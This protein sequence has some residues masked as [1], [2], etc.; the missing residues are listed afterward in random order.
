M[1]SI[2]LPPNVEPSSQAGVDSGARAS[3]TRTLVNLWPHIWPGDRADLKR[4]VVWS[5]VL[6]SIGLV[7][8][9]QI[10]KGKSILITVIFWLLGVVFT[11]GFAALGQMMS[12]AFVGAG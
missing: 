10:S 4:R 1:A 8:T 9:Y 12:S 3:L 5:L 2:D 7:A 11:V 6:M